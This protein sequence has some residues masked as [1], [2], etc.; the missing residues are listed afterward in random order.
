VL[1]REEQVVELRVPG[2]PRGHATTAGYF[3]DFVALADAALMLSGRVPGVYVTVN[4]INPALLARGRNR[5][6]PYAKQT[7]SDADVFRRRW[8]LIDLDP[9]R[10]SG[11]SSTRE[12]R[13]VALKRAGQCQQWLTTQGWPPP[14]VADSGNGFHL[15]YRLNLANDDDAKALVEGCLRA[16]A[17]RFSD[18]TVAVDRSVGNAARITKLYGTWACKSDATED[19]PHRLA[20][21]LEVPEPVVT[22]PAEQL[23]AL[24]AQTPAPLRAKPLHTNSGDGGRR[25][26]VPRWLEAHG[27]EYRPK[28][29]RDGRTIYRITCPFDPSHVDA[30]VMQAPDGQ[31]SA[32]C[33]HDSCADKGWAEFSAEIGAPGAGHYDSPMAQPAVAKPHQPIPAYRPFPLKALP[34]P[35]RGYSAGAA[36][37]I[38]CDVACVAVPLLPVL[39]AAVGNTRRIELKRGWTEPAVIWATVVAESGT[40]KSPALDAALAPVRQRQKAA[41]AEWK[42][43]QEAYKQE[44]L[45]ECIAPPVCNRY[46]TA[47][48]T[49]EA[50]AAILQDNPCGLLLARDELN[51]WLGSMDAYKNGKGDMAHYLE[52]HRASQMIVDRK[53]GPVP[54]IHVPRAALSIAGTTQPETFRRALGREHF[55]NGLLP[56]FLTVLPPQ[57]EREWS[58]QTVD[59]SVAESFAAVV[60][61]LY[62]IGFD[63][64][65]DGDEPFVLPLSPAAKE[66][67]IAF[68]NRHGHE[69]LALDG[70]LA[71]AWSRLEGYCARLALVIELADWA[72]APRP[73]KTPRLAELT[74]C[75]GPQTVRP[76][77]SRPPSR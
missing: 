19:R 8:L 36:A 40:L 23:E 48:A 3:D 73:K 45:K 7:T 30:A 43:A 27:I 20:R 22:V 69:Q 31:L 51:G 46:L 11:I 21:L 52:M 13:Q 6:E 60:N 12:Q 55:E 72:A 71:A 62:G 34:E 59:E 16:L 42:E 61:R 18:D 57:K 25:L 2:Y 75:E 24:A 4:E 58:E 53:T 56:R 63:P 26:N 66:A 10:P 33:F 17:E 28:R 32:K 77:A 50:L 74:A 54:L 38:G 14:V 68:Y 29:A 67:W 35:L 47:D 44:D 49:V 9:V 5:V 39:A 64:R 70:D 76:P 1:Y 37:S 15:L 41:V 65:L